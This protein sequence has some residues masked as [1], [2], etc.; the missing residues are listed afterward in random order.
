MYPVLDL[1][2]LITFLDWSPFNCL[3]SSFFPHLIQNAFSFIVNLTVKN[4]VALCIFSKHAISSSISV[5]LLNLAL[6]FLEVSKEIINPL[7]V[8]LSA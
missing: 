3:D 5:N 6:F 1:I 2:L 8:V 4:R 7:I